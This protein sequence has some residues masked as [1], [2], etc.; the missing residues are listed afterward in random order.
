MKKNFTLKN[1]LAVL[2]IAVCAIICTIFSSCS[3][4]DEQDT[5][6][7]AYL[8]I[9]DLLENKLSKTCHSEIEQLKKAYKEHN[10]AALSSY[11]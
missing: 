1:S 8:K 2:G 11:L 3:M 6:I 10:D 4:Y 9:N 5:T 7:I